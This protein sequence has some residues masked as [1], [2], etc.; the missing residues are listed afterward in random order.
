MLLQMALFRSFYGWIIFHCVYIYI[1]TTFYLFIYLLVDA[2]CFHVLVLI[3]SASVNI[4]VRVSFRVTVFSG[5]MPR[6]GIA[7]SYGKSIFSFSRNI[8]TVFHNGCTSLHSHQPFSPVTLI[9]RVLAL[10]PRGNLNDPYTRKNLKSLVRKMRMK[11]IPGYTLPTPF[12]SP[13]W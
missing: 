8:H 1:Y 6:S 9:L 3:N 4:W 12:S 13:D 5:Y 11:T 7:G 10:Y 2:G